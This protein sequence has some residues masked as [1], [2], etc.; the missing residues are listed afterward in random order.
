MF[1]FLFFCCSRGFQGFGKLLTL[2]QL[3]D[4]A[5]LLGGW[6]A[7]FAPVRFKQEHSH[8]HTHTIQKLVFGAIF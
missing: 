1:Y 8:T 5:C 7:C 2:S 4:R 6:S 3:E